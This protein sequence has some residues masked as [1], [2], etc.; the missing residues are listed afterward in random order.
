MF[1]RN[2]N[3]ILRSSALR[4]QP[5]LNARFFRGSAMVCGTRTSRRI[6]LIRVSKRWENG[7]SFWCTK[8]RNKSWNIKSQ[9][10]FIRC[11]R[12]NYSPQIL[13]HLPPWRES[14]HFPLLCS[15]AIFS[16]SSSLNYIQISFFNSVLL[17]RELVAGPQGSPSE[18]AP[19]VFADL[20]SR[21]SLA[22]IRFHVKFWF[23]GFLLFSAIYFPSYVTGNYVSPDID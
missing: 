11:Q 17:S 19:A 15:S 23:I 12:R 13:R 4:L 16:L 9:S 21:P 6:L 2:E 10:L 8:K 5:V 7:W 3:A 1:D 14:F 18:D 20:G 22:S